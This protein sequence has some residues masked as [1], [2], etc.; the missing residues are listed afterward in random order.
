M[1]QIAA[2]IPNGLKLVSTFSGCGGSSL[3]YRMAGFETLWA[4]EFV[5]LA[6][7]TYEANHPGVH[8]CPQDIRT[9]TAKQ[10]L[11]ETGLKKGELDV[12]E[13]SPPCSSFSSSGK[14][15]KGW[16]K[17]KKYSSTEQRADDL[18]YEFVRLVRGLKP[19]VFTAENVPGLVRGVA[20]GYFLD[21]IKK[22]KALGYRVKAQVLDAQWLGVPQTRS[23]LI[24][25]GVRND[26]KMDPAF[27]RPLAY[28]YS[29]KDAC[30]W[31][32]DGYLMIGKETHK[33]KPGN[34]FPRGARF[35]W[36]KPCPTIQASYKVV[37]GAPHTM[38]RNDGPDHFTVEELRRLCGFPDD[39]VLPGEY[40]HQW[41]RMGRAVPPPL[42]RAVAECIRDHVL[43]AAS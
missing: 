5:E 26:L 24:F 8:V 15:E 10:I 4:S 27:P 39:F 29:M 14:R 25:M 18:F 17:S 30:P 28:R 20:K 40:K 34:N 19:R 2:T 16:G 33:Q 42:M 35:H 6:R 32:N 38:R 31:L 21:I 3:G 43:C 41:E 11:K 36:H 9:V 1:K 23:R 13:G 12:L 37:G 7:E 22:M